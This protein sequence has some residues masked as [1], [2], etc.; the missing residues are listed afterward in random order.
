MHGARLRRS[1]AFACQALGEDI[2]NWLS[3]RSHP[4]ETP[5]L[6]HLSP[7]LSTKHAAVILHIAPLPRQES[8]HH[9]RSDVVPPALYLWEQK[10]SKP[11]RS[12]LTL[13]SSTELVWSARCCFSRFRTSAFISLLAK[14]RAASCAAL[15]ELLIATVATGQPLCGGSALIHALWHC[16]TR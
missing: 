12:I 7:S 4:G 13:A 3:S 9:T 1:Y 8:A 11:R 5:S 16:S 10:A 6:S 14:M 15:I 2:K